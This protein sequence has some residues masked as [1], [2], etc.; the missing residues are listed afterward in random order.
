MQAFSQQ[1]PNAGC[2]G[3]VVSPQLPL[4]FAE[5]P[6]NESVDESFPIRIESMTLSSQSGMD[7]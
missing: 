4:T 7:S 6:S 2:V 3:P 5:R 1:N